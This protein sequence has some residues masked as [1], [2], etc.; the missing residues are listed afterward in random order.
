[1]ENIIINEEDGKG[2]IPKVNFNASTGDCT[3]DGDSYMEN[4]V[5]FYE[6]LEGW[7][8]QY[9]KANNTLKLEIKL[10]YLNTSSSK[11][12]LDLLVALKKAEDQGANI[13]VK[14]FY[15]DPDS[16]IYEE[17]EDFVFESELEME[18]VQYDED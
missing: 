4:A 8:T 18:F 6:R 11:G 3:I 16:S 15:L 5:E 17:G 14:W 2:F 10:K 7:V 1:M 12:I 13:S 9:L